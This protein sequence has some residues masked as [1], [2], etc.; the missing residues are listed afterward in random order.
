[1]SSAVVAK[2]SRHDLDKLNTPSEAFITNAQHLC[3]YNWKNDSVPTIAVPGTP[4]L[5]APSKG[6]R[7][8][9]KD[10]GLVFIDQNAD[11]HPIYPLE[12]LFRALYLTDSKFKIGSVDVVTDRN[13]IR[14]LLGFVKPDSASHGLESFT[15]KVEVCKGTALFCRQTPS[16]R[17]FIA[18]GEFRGYGHEYEKAYTKAEISDSS[19]HHRVISYRLGGLNFIIRHETDGYIKKEI[20]SHGKR[21]DKDNLAALLDSLSL[22]SSPK[23]IGASGP[24]GSK[25][26]VEE[27]GSIVPLS[28]TLEIKTR[29]SHKPIPFH[30]VAPQLWVSQ[31]PNLV[32]AYHVR[33][34]FQ[35]AEAEEVSAELAKWEKDNQKHLRRL[36]ALIAEIIKR[37]EDCGGRAVLRYDA[38]EDRMILSRVSDGGKMLP[39]DLYSKWMEAGPVTIGDSSKAV[40]QQAGKGATVTELCL[41]TDSVHV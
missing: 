27:E 26:V 7:Q 22:S 34:K 3:S 16:T 20:P 14:K 18:A 2:I 36:S 39:T 41:G 24:S 37:V 4:P 30:E 15:I 6:S 40:Q 23:P 9:K 29:V 33:G 19:G 5:W 25:L 28:S 31:T 8:L 32:R 17:E 12:P 10:S 35:E 21:P 1:M 11:R 13:N 38:M